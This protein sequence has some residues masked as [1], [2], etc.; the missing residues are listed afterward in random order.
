MGESKQPELDTPPEEKSARERVKEVT[1]PDQPLDNPNDDDI[2]VPPPPENLIKC[3]YYVAVTED[4]Q[5]RFDITGTSSD[6]VE[7]L[8]LHSI[9]GEKLSSVLDRLQAG[10]YSY[11]TKELGTLDKKLDFV[12]GILSQLLEVISSTET[13][14]TQDKQ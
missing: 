8:G 3:G 2:P 7:L 9:A 12:T 13:K 10:K 6:I 14:T 1:P 11:I 4:G 5:F